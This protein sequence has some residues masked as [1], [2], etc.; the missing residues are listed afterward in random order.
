MGQTR[1]FWRAFLRASRKPMTCRVLII[2]DNE[3]DL[4]FARLILDRLGDAFEVI[5][6]ESAKEAL[7]FLRNQPDH[8]IQLILL[9]INMP[10]M[11]GFE[12]LADYENLLAEQRA[13][14]VVVMLTSSPDPHDQARAATFSAVRGYITK[15]IDKLSAQGLLNLLQGT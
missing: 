10:G 13:N 3:N 8:G 9:D 1:T 15:P 6:Q 11:N 5:E 12:F 4:L 7:A 2:D 14:A